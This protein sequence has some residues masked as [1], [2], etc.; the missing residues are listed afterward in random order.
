MKKF[1]IMMAVVLMGTGCYAQ[2]KAVN[3]AKNKAMNTEAPDFAG[4][5]QD[6]KAALEDAETKD[7][8]NT[9]YVAG[10]IGYKENEYAMIQAQFGNAKDDEKVGKAVVE[11]F[12]YWI[13]ADQIAMTPTLDKKGRE[14]TDVKTRKQIADKIAEYYRSQDLI[15]Y[16]IYLND[17]REYAEA[18]DVFMRHLS[19]PDLDMMKEAKYQKEMPKDT[20][21]EQYKYYA[22]IFAAQSENHANA[23]KIFE[24]MKN[25][26]YEAVTINQLLYQEYLAIKDTANFVRV[27]QDA[28]AMF[29]S[30]PWFLQNLINHYIFSGQE[31]KAIEYLDKAIERE[32]NVAQYHH[33]KGNLN[34]NSKNYDAAL[35]EFDAAIALDPTLAD[36]HA[37]KGRV[38]YNQAVKMNEESAYIVDQKA[39]NKALK[40]M[41]EMF[42]QAL[43]FFE[44][45]HRIDPKN[46]DYMIILK[47]LY[48]RFHMDDKNAAIAE[49]LSNL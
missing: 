35:A 38:Y 31:N 15:K 11:S 41:N 13:K 8:A 39:Y 48:Y 29:P 49:E 36:A 30:E 7:Q 16:G 18:Y 3:S 17:K 21:Y 34:E 26:S 40:E 22:G 42:H 24:E 4:A 10:L 45:A 19:I 44:E 37:G 14:V 1:A 25:G 20:I 12:D 33:I 5:R 9:W 6:I 32:P 47:G 2:K 43:P 27:L 28:T 23:I 46:R